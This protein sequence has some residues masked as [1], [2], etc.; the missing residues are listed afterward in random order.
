HHHQIDVRDQRALGRVV[1]IGAAA[2]EGAAL[3]D[4]HDAGQRPITPRDVPDQADQVAGN[5]GGAAELTGTHRGDRA[6]RSGALLDDR[7]PPPAVHGDH[8]GGDGVL[9]LGPVLGTRPRA[10]PAGADADIALVVLAGRAAHA[11]STAGSGW[12]I[13]SHIPTKSGRVFWVVPMLT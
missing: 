2:Q 1:V 4:A 3:L 9:M 5:D 13:A 7:P 6:L 8:A 11:S 10:A 12:S